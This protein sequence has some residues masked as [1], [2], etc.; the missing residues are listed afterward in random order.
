MPALPTSPKPNAIGGIAVL[1]LS[2]TIL[3]VL[4]ASGKWMLE[5]SVALLVVVWVRYL[6][7]FL[8]ILALV[9]AK[10]D[11][12]LFVSNNPRYQWLRGG[13]I[14]LTTMSFFTTLSYLPQAQATT[15]LFL[16]PLL[17]LAL[18]PWL[19]GESKRL[20]RW[21]AAAAGFVGVMIVVRPGAGLDA[22][23]VMFGLLTAALMALQHILTRKVAI[24]HPLTTI[25]WSGLIGAAILTLIVPIWLMVDHTQ[26][27]SIKPLFSSLNG[28]VLLSMGLTGLV[29]HLLQ[30]QA[31]RLAAASLL[32]PFMYLQIVSSSFMGW[33][34]WGDFPDLVSWLGI[35]LIC[36]SGAGIALY[37]WRRPSAQ[38]VSP[39][40]KRPA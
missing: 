21:L 8:L 29:G 1:L 24:D 28:L 22:V 30:V 2:L 18:A 13:T 35:V 17:I 16:A 25:I 19:L 37:E 20:S 9:A 32:A 11:W 3:S 36:A 6:V 23:G 26:W 38:T 12:H 10:G 40:T 27:A 15:M 33:L 34:I 14:L 7:H 39:D 4:D 31:Y 5:A